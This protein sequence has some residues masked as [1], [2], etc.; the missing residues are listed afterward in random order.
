MSQKSVSSNKSL[1]KIKRGRSDSIVN[2]AKTVL[3]K[4]EQK[5]PISINSSLPRV[6]KTSFMDSRFNTTVST[7]TP[8]N[9]KPK[10]P[11]TKKKKAKSPR[12]GKHIK[13]TKKGGRKRTRRRRKKKRTRRRRKKKRRKSRKKRLQ[14]GGTCEM[15]SEVKKIMDINKKIG[16]LSERQENIINEL[17]YDLGDL[18]DNDEVL[19][20]KVDE[21][22]NESFNSDY[23]NAK[24]NE[25]IISLL[26]TYTLE[27]QTNNS[28]RHPKFYTITN[29]MLDDYETN[30]KLFIAIQGFFEHKGWGTC[31]D[32]IWPI[33]TQNGNFNSYL[34]NFHQR[35]LFKKKI[36]EMISNN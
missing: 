4:M 5:T 22:E 13:N 30:K 24:P 34:E 35:N 9:R 21:A 10:K 15:P 7:L 25:E 29:D 6:T 2:K 19:N 27:V 16:Q 3:K 33:R 32:Y 31:E 36:Q 23:L 12:V 20:K 11:K 28:E 8:T 14:K 26:K 18:I 17:T 1:V